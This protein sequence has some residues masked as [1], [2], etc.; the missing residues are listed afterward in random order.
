MASKKKVKE[1]KETV[2]DHSLNFFKSRQV[3]NG[4]E[5]KELIASSGDPYSNV[6]SGK[7]SSSERRPPID[8]TRSP[9]EM[10]SGDDPVQAIVVHGLADP[11]DPFFDVYVTLNEGN[12]VLFDEKREDGSWSTRTI[13]IERAPEVEAQELE[14]TSA[15][16]EPISEELAA[17]MRSRA[18]SSGADDSAPA[19]VVALEEDSEELAIPEVESTATTEEALREEESGATQESGR[20]PSNSV[21]VLDSETAALLAAEL[22][23]VSGKS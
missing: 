4:K 21:G 18:K 10:G 9:D 23:R 7:G 1:Q 13:R 2:F 15:G 11:E 16:W 20:D 19:E 12:G 5:T 6:S 22:K 8:Y 17:Q 14:K 3:K